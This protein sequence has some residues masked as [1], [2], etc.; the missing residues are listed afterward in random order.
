[1]LHFRYPDSSW[2]VCA[3]QHPFTGLVTLGTIILAFSLFG[4]AGAIGAARSSACLIASRDPGLDFLLEHN[5]LTARIANNTRTVRF[6][7]VGRNGLGAAVSS[8]EA[9]RPSTAEWRAGSS[10]STMSVRNPPASHQP[11]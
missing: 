2:D 9:T 1:M 6:H 8:R 11:A 3:S 10:W 7:R 5:V 4:V